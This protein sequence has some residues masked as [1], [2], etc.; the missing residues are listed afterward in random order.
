MATGKEATDQ[1]R[2]F[3]QYLIVTGLSPHKAVKWDAQEKRADPMLPVN[4]WPLS[5]LVQHLQEDSRAFEVDAQRD[6][7]L[8]KCFAIPE[9]FH[10]R[11]I[12]DRPSHE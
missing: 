8:L 10:A 11:N 1:T 4:L 12:A 3:A 6:Q 7:V 9:T 5:K 2:L